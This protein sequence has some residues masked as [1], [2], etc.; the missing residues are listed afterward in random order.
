M[1]CD[2]AVSWYGLM[3]P[4][5]TPSPVIER[6]YRE[7]QRVLAVPAVRKKLVDVDMEPIG[8]NPEQ[9]ASA[10]EA[11]IPIWSKLIRASG[12]NISSQ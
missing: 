7:T 9:F 11:E 3:V 1:S 10:V 5:A 2:E 8:N 6:L 4:A 12:L